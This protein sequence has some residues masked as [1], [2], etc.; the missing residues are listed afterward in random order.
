MRLDNHPE[1]ASATISFFPGAK[2]RL[3]TQ[4][5]QQSDTLNHIHSGGCRRAAIDVPRAISLE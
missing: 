5:S 2:D 3:S 1:R 4:G